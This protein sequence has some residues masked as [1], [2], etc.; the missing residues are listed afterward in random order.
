MCQTCNHFEKQR[1]YHYGTWRVLQHGRLWLDRCWRR[2]AA[3]APKQ[4]SDVANIDCQVVAMQ[5]RVLPNEQPEGFLRCRLVA[6]IFWLNVNRLRMG[7][8]SPSAS[9]STT[10]QPSRSPTDE[11]DVPSSSTSTSVKNGFK[12]FVIMQLF[13]RS[14]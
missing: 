7:G 8:T 12:L 5:K 4:L 13:A 10:P 1:P 9:R 2:W 11:F 14:T 6:P 3:I